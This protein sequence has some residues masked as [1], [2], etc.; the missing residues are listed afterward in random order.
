M[1]EESERIAELASEHAY[2]PL[3][4]TMIKKGAEFVSG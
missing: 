1:V 3:R 2:L 4:E